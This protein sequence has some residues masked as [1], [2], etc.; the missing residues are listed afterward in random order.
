MLH[1]VY[2]ELVLN[3]DLR[4]ERSESNTQLIP[5]EEEKGYT[6]GK[7]YLC[8]NAFTHISIHIPMYF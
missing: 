3:K 1:T 5:N 8:Y 2:I 7:D 4:M 6:N